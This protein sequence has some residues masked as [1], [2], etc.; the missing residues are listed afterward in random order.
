MSSV[1]GR[2]SYHRFSTPRSCRIRKHATYIS[3]ATCQGLHAQKSTDAVKAIALKSTLHIVFANTST[4]TR[5]D[6]AARGRKPEIIPNFSDHRGF[7]TCVQV[8]VLAYTKRIGQQ[9]RHHPPCPPHPPPTLQACRASL[10]FLVRII[11]DQSDKATK[12]TTLYMPIIRVLYCINQSTPNT[13]Q[14]LKR[15]CCCCRYHKTSIS[16]FFITIEILFV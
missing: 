15:C 6:W 7:R 5:V 4:A 13:K 16:S 2:H 12:V 1:I 10:V 9:Q 14:N 11:M 3:H 8:P